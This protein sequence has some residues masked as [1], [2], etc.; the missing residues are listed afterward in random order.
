MNKTSYSMLNVFSATCSGLLSLIDPIDSRKE[1]KN[2]SKNLKRLQILDMFYE[3]NKT[4]SKKYMDEIAEL[5]RTL[6]PKQDLPESLKIL[7]LPFADC[8][9]VYKYIY[10]KKN[11]GSA[12]FIIFPFGMPRIII[13]EKDKEGI[14]ETAA[15]E[16][17]HLIH[18]LECSKYESKSN[19]WTKNNILFNLNYHNNTYNSVEKI[20]DETL[21]Y[22]AEKKALDSGLF[23]KKFITQSKKNKFLMPDRNLDKKSKGHIYDYAEYY[24]QELT[25]KYGVENAFAK[26]L[27]LRSQEQIKQLL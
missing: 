19:P 14:F 23:S 11:E 4:L 6:R 18:Y 10:E 7:V 20:V 1:Y 3:K 24:A 25:K 16:L 13:S 17:G 5:Y 27:P 12:G 2:I 22:I 15:H 8:D 26:T 9:I 21:A